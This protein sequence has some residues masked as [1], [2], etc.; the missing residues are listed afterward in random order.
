MQTRRYPWGIQRLVSTHQLQHNP[1]VPRSVQICIWGLG[2][3]RVG[4]CV[5]QTKSTQ[6]AKICPNLNFRREGEGRGSWFR[7]TFLKYLSGGTQ[8]ILSTNFAMPY[9]G[10]P[11]I[12]DSLSHT[13]CVET[14]KRYQSIQDLVKGARKCY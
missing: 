12:T 14:N 6:S 10:R 13:T 5:V 2:G 8:G 4:G 11:C 1:K 9:S 3:W 7:P